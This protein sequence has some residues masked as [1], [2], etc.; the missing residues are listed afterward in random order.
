[1]KLLSRYV[2]RE[3]IPP[4]GIGLAVFTFLLVV[5]QLVL[6]MD[7]F[8]NRG[9][10]LAVIF[11]M[12]ALVLPMFLPL[13]IPMAVLLAA[14]LCYG[15]LSE[16][17]EITAFRSAGLHLLAYSWP[18]LVLGLFLSFLLVYLNLDLAPRAAMEFKNIHFSVASQ[19]P[20]A[21]FSPKVMNNFGEYQIY[22]EKMDR[23][24]QKISGV[25]IYRLNPDS[26]PT[27]ITAPRGEVSTVPNEGL[28]LELTDGTIYQ[29]S[30][31]KESQYTITKFNRF[32][33]RV[34]AQARDEL[35]PVSAREMTFSEL[36][37]KARKAEQEHANPSSWIKETQ[38]RIAVAFAPFLF[39]LLG[40]VLGVRV[41]RGSKSIGVG[42]SLIVILI[43]YGLLIFMTSIASKGVW[44][45]LFLAWVPNLLALALGGWLWRKAAAR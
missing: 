26:G 3:F 13:S 10:E 1:M 9:V 28:T 34:S 39:L 23:R 14:L 21:L 18:N 32:A 45:I 30:Q 43:Y 38:V 7:L 4:F 5:R 11:K 17:G 33:L 31:D 37:K 15:R 42:A 40:T 16:D 27:R 24:K 8:L 19:N 12:S 35:R 29:P 22:V 44:M 41:R 2:I 36:R 20:L 25:T 6:V